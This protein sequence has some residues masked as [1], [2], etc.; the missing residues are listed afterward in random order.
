M[1][2][3]RGGDS[4]FDKII[5]PI[6]FATSGFGE[7]AVRAGVVL[8]ALVLLSFLANSF[9]EPV[10]WAELPGSAAI[11]YTL[12]SIPFAKDLKGYGWVRLA[13]GFWQLL[14]AVQFTLFALAVRN[15]FR[16]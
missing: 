9:K 13:R 16:R 6:Y 15:R 14:I 2:M 4:L 1:E 10:V 12:E 11:E 5:L 3:K 7:R 8:L